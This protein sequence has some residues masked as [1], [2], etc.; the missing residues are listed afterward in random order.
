MLGVVLFWSA[1]FG[2]SLSYHT[3]HPI[4]AAAG[5][6]SYVIKDARAGIK[7]TVQR[8]KQK[9]TLRESSAANILF[10]TVLILPQQNLGFLGTGE[11]GIKPLSQVFFLLKQKIVLQYYLTELY[12]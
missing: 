10:S 4:T 8:A 7:I 6:I 3:K 9:I 2:D 11:N 1:D 5:A 12:N